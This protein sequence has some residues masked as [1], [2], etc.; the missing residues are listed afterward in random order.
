MNSRATLIKDQTDI[1]KITRISNACTLIQIGRHAILTDPWFK[2]TWGFTEEPGLDAERLPFLTA[3]VGSHATIGHWDIGSLRNCSD[4]D[5]TQVITANS[6]MTRRARKVGFK[7]VSTLPWGESQEIAPDLKIE[8]VESKSLLGIRS[9]NYVIS[10]GNTRV[11]FGGETKLLAPLQKYSKTH[12]PVDVALVPSNGM[13]MLG[14]RLV[15]NVFEALKASRI[16]GART[17]IPIH[18]SMHYIGIGGP[19]SAARFLSEPV[20]FGIR[21]SHLKAGVPTMIRP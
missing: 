8:S 10:S 19:T 11:F 18:D 14:F 7:S 4:K 21:I 17:L 3:I 20:E 13:S 6:I 2:K 16:L 5:S 15:T 1:L 12:S 9:N